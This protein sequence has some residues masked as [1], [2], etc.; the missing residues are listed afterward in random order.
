MNLQEL[1]ISYITITKKDIIRFIRIWPQTFLP[2]IITTTLYFLVFGKVI[3]KQIQYVEGMKYISY[4]MPGLVMMS[5]I[6]GSYSNSVSSFFSNKF[7]KSIEELL[8]SPTPNYIILLGYVTGAVIRGMISGLLVFIVSIVFIDIKITFPFLVVAT[9]FLTSIIFAIVGL[10]NGIFAKNVDDVSWIPS[11]I[12][13]P[14]SYLG[15]IFYSIKDLPG[16]WSK[17]SLFNPIFYCIDSLRYGF[18][19]IQILDIKFT[20]VAI[21]LLIL[22]LWVISLKL[23]ENRLRS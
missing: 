2:N 7:Q 9:I 5:V 18:L 17:V 3:G 4:I 14:L 6:N 8:V 22:I 10:V 21:I 13:T 23:M 20:I 11:F 15:G 12:L 19:G 1:L 16:I